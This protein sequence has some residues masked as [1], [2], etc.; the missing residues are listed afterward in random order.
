MSP[1]SKAQQKATAKYVKENYDRIEIKV[2][3]GK[4][5]VYRTHGAVQGKPERFFDPCSRRS[6]GA[7]RTEIGRFVGARIAC[8][9]IMALTRIFQTLFPKWKFAASDSLRAALRAVARWTPAAAGVRGRT[10]GKRET[11]CGFLPLVNHLLSLRTR[12]ARKNK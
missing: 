11:T 12:C 4:K 7:R 8:P 9:G 1:V 2:P 10:A 5:E 6:H 3:K